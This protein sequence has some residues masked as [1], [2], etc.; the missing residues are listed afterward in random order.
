MLLPLP[1]LPE[2]LSGV[3][4]AVPRENGTELRRMTPE[5]SAFYS[6][7][8]AFRI[9]AGAPAGVRIRFATD[10]RSFAMKIAYGGEARQLYAADVTVDRG[11]VR[12]FTPG[13]RQE[14]FRF[15]CPLPGGE[16][17]VE[18]ALPNLVECP[19][20][21]IELEKGAAVSPLPPRR[22]I[23]F[24]GDSITQGMTV[25]HP[26]LAW[27]A[28]YAARHDFDFVNLAVGGA[29]MRA[30]LGKFALAYRWQEAFVAYGVND[31][32]QSRPIPEFLDDARGMLRAL[33]SRPEAI[34]RLLTPIPL[35]DP[36]R[37]VNANGD[38]LQMFRD[39]LRELAARE[40][41]RVKVIDGCSLVP[42]D[43]AFY[44]DRLHPNDRG[45][46]LFAENLL[47]RTRS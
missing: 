41:P 37:R 46:I 27:P 18:I 43:S 28:R 10:A 34:I 24:L 8:E 33:L 26:A 5:L 15:E 3:A 12:S 29:T 16:H 44:A 36:A 31:F 4:E 42:G 35:P 2:L 23:L 30:S 9:R 45:A 25:T 17:A 6:G 22:T 11:E 32:T 20:V 21:E 14:E 13:S 19:A 47:D 38:T 1:E 39:G 7:S 40:F